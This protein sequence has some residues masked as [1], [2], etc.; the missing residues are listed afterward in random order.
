MEKVIN[1][2]NTEGRGDAKGAQL[3][4]TTAHL[5]IKAGVRIFSSIWD[6]QYFK[7]CT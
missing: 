6:L 5:M 1:S 2:N 7:S 3:G 4:C